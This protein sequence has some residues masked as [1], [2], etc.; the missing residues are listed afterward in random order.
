MR[1]P[2]E[3]LPA[4][5]VPAACGNPPSAVAWKL[6]ASGKQPWVGGA[7]ERY[8]AVFPLLWI[9]G[10]ALPVALILMP[11]AAVVSLR[12]RGALRYAWPWYAV[13]FAQLLSVVTNWVLVDGSWSALL[14]H[15]AGSYV[16]GWFVIGAA[17]STG[18][19][20]VVSLA[21]ATTAVS[22]IAWYWAVLAV[23]ALAAALVWPV[24]RFIFLTPVGHLLPAGLPATSFSFSVF[25]F[26]W[27]ELF[28]AELPRIVVL[29][30]WANVLG[31]AGIAVI[32]AG[33]AE[34]SSRR[35]TLPIIGTGMVAA[36]I[37]RLPILALAIVLVLRTWLGLRS[38]PAKV[39]AITLPLWAATALALAI[40]VPSNL[41][42]R[43]NEGL[44]EGRPG[45]SQ[46]RSDVY[47]AN[48]R[49]FYEAPFIGHGWPGEA[50]IDVQDEAFGGAGGGAVAGSHSTVSGLLYKGGLLAFM[51][52]VAALVLTILPLAR[53]VMTSAHAKS[54][55]CFVAALALACGAEGVEGFAVPLLS[56]F[57]WL[58]AVLRVSAAD[59]ETFG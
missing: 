34:R 17:I 16:S 13:G 35:W 29:F 56:V 46:V 58:G 54:A 38:V 57:I 18:A 2:F 23:P 6:D 59:E 28:G 9:T 44:D 42:A 26:A 41:M 3:P 7:L 22:R 48:W 39:L 11:A 32:L 21:V 10:L 20:G 40:G 12:G 49:G 33:L 1:V 55:L 15:L 31:V 8:F 45:S 52:L 30:P 24:Q 53:R 27:D 14:K 50:V 51:P 37:G 5:S 4:V 36:S 19:A 47:E 43:V 25:V